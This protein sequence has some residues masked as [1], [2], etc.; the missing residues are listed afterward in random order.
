M[1][2]SFM[3]TSTMVTS[4]RSNS[5]YELFYSNSVAA[6]MARLREESSVKVYRASGVTSEAPERHMAAAAK[7]SSPSEK[8]R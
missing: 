8:I 3:V 4:T 2:A 6:S 5:R 7:L 1:I